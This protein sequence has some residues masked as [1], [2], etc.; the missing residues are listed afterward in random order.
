MFSRLKIAAAIL[1]L[2]LAACQ[3]SAYAP[4]PVAEAQAAVLQPASS[5]QADAA[6]PEVVELF[7]SQGCSSCPPANA[8]V[9]P[10]ADRPDKLVLSWQVTYWDHLG[11]KDKFADPAYTERQW[12]YARALKHDQVWTPQ[13][14]VNGRGDVV[15]SNPA[16]LNN[17]LNKYQRGKGGPA[18]AL[19]AGKVTVTGATPGVQVELVRYDP[20]IVQVPIKAG[21]N[22]G[23]TLPHR[24][25]VK[26]YA[27]LG[28]VKGST[29][30][31]TLPAAKQAGLKTAVLVAERPGGP[32]M[33]AAHD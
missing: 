1:P 25:V 3:Q 21:E 5:P 14:V 23:A 4:Q 24:N 31:F 32:I 12:R 15:G 13:V 8:L 7:Q 2:A 11:W 10:L 27:M 28:D 29:M 20:R 17:A 9:M 16:E 26:E 18:I 6:H 33:A 30:A 19:S 22:S